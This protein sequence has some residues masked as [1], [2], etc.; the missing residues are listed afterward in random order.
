MLAV[1]V[2]SCTARAAPGPEIRVGGTGVGTLLLERMVEAYRAVKHDA[3]VRTILPP[4][5][6]SGSLRALSAGAVDLA[7]VTFAPGQQNSPLLDSSAV[8]IPWVVTPM[9]F[10][11]RDLPKGM[12]FT[13]TQV[14]DIYAGRWGQWPD[15]S[16]IRLITRTETESDTRLLRAVSPAMNEAVGVALSRLGLPVA[17]ND[18]L[19][20]QMLERTPGS[21]GMLALGQITLTKSVLKPAELDGTEPTVDNLRSGMYRLT[22]PLYIVLPRNPSKEVIAFSD[23]LQSHGSLRMLERMN[24]TPIAR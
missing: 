19:N 3:R 24:F 6:S 22:K 5:G 10:T 20:Q 14:A 21:F 13:L 12:K 7:V 17:E 9:V 23:Y 15:G 4:M 16:P 2:F 11:G 1:L 18:L 8:V